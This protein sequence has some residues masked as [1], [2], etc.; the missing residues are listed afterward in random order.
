MRNHHQNTSK[1]RAKVSWKL[2]VLLAK[3]LEPMGPHWLVEA[4]PG[5]IPSSGTAIP[6]YANV[7]GLRASCWVVLGLLH[8]VRGI[9]GA[10]IG[11]EGM[12]KYFP[13]HLKSCLRCVDLCH[14]C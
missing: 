11:A 5:E 10:G 3:L 9:Q 6:N 13:A 2:G 4:V 1:A 8:P 12:S 14:L 7:T